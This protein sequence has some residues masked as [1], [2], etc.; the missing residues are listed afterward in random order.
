MKPIEIRPTII[1][2]PF[3]DSDGNEVLK[4]QFDRSDDNVKKF[5]AVIP[6]MAE[7]INEIEAN[8]DHDFD[9]KQFIGKLADSFLGDGAFDKIYNLNNSTF[10]AAKYIYQIAIGIK[11]EMEDEDKKAVLSKY[12]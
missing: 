6:E 5:Y 10:T 4:L 8:P 12:K 1:D 11:E 9:E 7:K 2:I 3:I